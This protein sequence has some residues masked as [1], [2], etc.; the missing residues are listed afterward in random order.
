[1]K[2]RTLFDVRQN[3]AAFLLVDRWRELRGRVQEVSQLLVVELCV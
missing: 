1:M 2:G 3:D